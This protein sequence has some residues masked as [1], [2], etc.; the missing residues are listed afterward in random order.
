[1]RCTFHTKILQI[2]QVE[3]PP[4]N[5]SWLKGDTA[6]VLTENQK[7]SPLSGALPSNTCFCVQEKAEIIRRPI[8]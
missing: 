4:A 6:Q 3:E 2:S 8:Y 7:G 5:Y 1:M